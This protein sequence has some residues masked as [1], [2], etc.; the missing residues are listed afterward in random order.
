MGKKIGMGK[1]VLLRHGQSLWNAKNIFTGYVDVSLSVKGIEEALQ[2]GEVMKDFVF[3]RVYVSKLMRA[4]M[5]AQLAFSKMRDD[6]V[7]VLIDEESPPVLDKEIEKDLLF[8]CETE[9]LNERHYGR[10]QGL[11]KQAVKDEFG[12]ERFR[13]WRRSYDVAPPGGE[14]LKMT[15]ERSLP[16]FKAKIL[17]HM[18]KGE[19]ILVSAHGNSIRGI[20]MY[21]DKLSEVEV[22]SLEIPTG[23]P[24]V[25]EYKKES[26][27][28]GSV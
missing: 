18:K 10:L 28:K 22:T 17:P 15:I 25:Y 21:L 2:A 7:L 11:N 13:L 5:T 8:M 9:A 23:E 27:V 26:W 19:T 12:E 4:Q 20:I 16:Y 1:L 3:D 24:I 6:R 14:S